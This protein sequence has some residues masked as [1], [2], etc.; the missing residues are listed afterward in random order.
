M[1]IDADAADADADDANADS[2]NADDASSH[3]LCSNRGR[4]AKV[5]GGEEV[6]PGVILAQQPEGGLAGLCLLG[7]ALLPLVIIERIVVT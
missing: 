6:C 7:G 5:R 1:P 2:D 4:N 3:S